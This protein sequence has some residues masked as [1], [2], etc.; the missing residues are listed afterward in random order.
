MKDGSAVCAEPSPRNAYFWRQ[1]TK[2]GLRIY[3]IFFQPNR[4]SLELDPRLARNIRFR[5]TRRC[6]QTASPIV[7]GPAPILSESPVRFAANYSALRRS[8]DRF[9]T[10]LP[11]E[12]YE[13]LSQQLVRFLIDTNCPGVTPPTFHRTGCQERR[14]VSFLPCSARSN[15][16]LAVPKNATYNHPSSIPG[17]NHGRR[18]KE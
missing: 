15:L 11:S 14:C 2:Q 12:T 6:L 13:L 7:I 3:P 5:Q 16:S 17:A 1:H 18:Q 10:S 9:S 8:C 4:R